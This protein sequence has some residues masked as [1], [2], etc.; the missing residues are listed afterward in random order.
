MA[1]PP[2]YSEPLGDETFAARLYVRASARTLR[3][4]VSHAIRVCV[5]LVGI[6]QQP[7]VVVQIVDAVVVVVVVASVACATLVGVE[8]VCVGNKWTVVMAEAAPVMIDVDM[9]GADQILI[10]CAA[11]VVLHGA[12]AGN[13]PAR[14]GRGDGV[15]IGPR[16]GR[17]AIDAQRCKGGRS[18][19]DSAVSIE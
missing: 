13:Q 14:G 2:R 10:G 19:P 18:W 1:L 9:A 11:T 6:G 5:G 12:E 4:S 16:G 8:L 3:T 7:A 15:P 17:R